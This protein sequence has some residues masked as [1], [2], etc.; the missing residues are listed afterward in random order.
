MNDGVVVNVADWLA[1]V[2]G[3]W[4]RSGVHRV[5]APPVEQVEEVRNAVIFFAR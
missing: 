1:S 4:C 3:R 5:H 2:T